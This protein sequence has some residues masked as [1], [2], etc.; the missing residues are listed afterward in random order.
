MCD[1][2]FSS[3]ITAG[4]LSSTSSADVS[5]LS[6]TGAGGGGS[7]CWLSPMLI[8]VMEREGLGGEADELASTALLPAKMEVSCVRRIYYMR[9]KYQACSCSNTSVCT[10][11]V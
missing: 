2:I 10:S 6:S 7:G 4:A 5:T 8:L 3:L 1:F 9:K 11:N